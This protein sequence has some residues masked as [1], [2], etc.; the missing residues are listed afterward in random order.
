MTQSAILN[1]DAAVNLTLGGLLVVFPRG[2]M[3]VLGV[4]IP[5][6]PFYAS[7]LGAVLLGIGLALIV[8]VRGSRSSGGVWALSAQSR[9]ISAVRRCCCFSGSSL[10]SLVF[11]FEVT[12]S[13]GASVPW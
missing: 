12:C 5:E 9:S 8:D 3:L 10:A 7:I 6:T 11:R 4:P 13:S 2:V 1:I